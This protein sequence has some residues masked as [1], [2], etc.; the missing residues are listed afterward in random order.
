MP[1]VYR[2]T[3]NNQ[4]QPVS[5]DTTD[6][7]VEESVAILNNRNANTLNAKRNQGKQLESIISPQSF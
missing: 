6:V 7:I 2:I 3:V 5:E 1:S 4:H